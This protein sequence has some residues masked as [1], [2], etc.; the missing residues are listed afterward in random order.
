MNVADIP[1]RLRLV[2]RPHQDPKAFDP[3]ATLEHRAHEND[4]RRIVIIGAGI[5]GLTMA[6]LL[7][8]R[9]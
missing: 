2:R 7:E 3:I 6:W 5:A 4:N 1:H 8:R 9:G